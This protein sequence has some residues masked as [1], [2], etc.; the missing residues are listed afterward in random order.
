MYNLSGNLKPQDANRQTMNAEFHRA[1]EYGQVELVTKMLKNQ[2]DL[3]SDRAE[4]DFL[5]LHS[6]VTFDWSEMAKLLLSFGAD[7]NA[8]NDEGIAALHLAAS[9]EMVDILLAAGADINLPSKDGSTPLY[10]SASEADG[11]EAVEALLRHGADSTLRTMHG[12][13]PLD[14]ATLRE[15][16]DKVEVLKA[17]LG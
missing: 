6:A 10:V 3:V 12:E 9:S 1:V 11:L 4:F 15:E 5:A 2:P 13:S 16:W 8:V 14:I 7:P 17:A